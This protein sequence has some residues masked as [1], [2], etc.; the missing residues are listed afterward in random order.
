MAMKG[1]NLGG[2]LVLEKW[3]TPSL[4]TDTAA[5]D[6]YALMQTLG[7]HAEDVLNEHR[8]TFITESDFA[9]LSARGIEAVRIPVGYWIFGDEAPFIKSIT[10]LDSA[11]RWA[12][13]HN[14]KVLIDFH[15][16]PGSQNGWDHSGRS[17]SIG[18]Q[19]DTHQQKSLGVLAKLAERYGNNPQLW[20]IEVLNEPHWDIPKK[21]LANYYEAAY[22]IIRQTAPDSVAVVI[23]D[24]FR[25][26]EWGDV[27]AKPLFTNVVLDRH[28]YQCFD[29]V[30]K[31]L[32]IPGHVH[33]AEKL[34]CEE[35]DGL[36]ILKPVIAGE[37]SLALDGDVTDE[38]RAAYARA[39]LAAMNRTTAWFFWTYKTEESPEWDMRKSARLLGLKPK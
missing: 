1:V 17:G 15:A 3:I 22:E 12:T 32:D 24:A 25:P 39:E 36:Q 9:W 4:F 33:K 28:F 27:L 23:S 7:D 11:F 14:I 34:W 38:D 37:W 5:T 19:D 20:G 8:R 26:Y 21:T 10:Y 18:W 29:D 2:W 6:E 31:A 30:D 16:A 13:A 35:V